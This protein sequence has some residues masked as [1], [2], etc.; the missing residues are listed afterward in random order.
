MFNRISLEFQIGKLYWKIKL[1][2]IGQFIGRQLM[3]EQGKIKFIIN[4]ILVYYDLR[5]VIFF[6][7]QEKI[8]RRITYQRF[9]EKLIKKKINLCCFGEKK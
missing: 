2:N 8:L 3:L 9:N 6:M 4:K 5:K 1:N 7:K